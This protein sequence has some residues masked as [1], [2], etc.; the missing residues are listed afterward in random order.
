MIER[1]LGSGRMWCAQALG[2]V[3]FVAETDY[4]VSVFTGDKLGAGTDAN[5][6]VAMTGEFGDSGE[7]ELRDSGNVNKFERNQVPQ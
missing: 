2:T 5:V 3:R 7:R 6:F 1:S 4:T